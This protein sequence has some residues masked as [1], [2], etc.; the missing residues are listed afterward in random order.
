MFGHADPLNGNGRVVC[1]H[2]GYSVD[3]EF[4][5]AVDGEGR[6]VNRNSFVAHA[7]TCLWIYQ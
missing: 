7:G 5:R 2:G 6:D 1:P 4:T 3:K